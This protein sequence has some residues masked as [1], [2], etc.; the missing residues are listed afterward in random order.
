MPSAPSTSCWRSCGPTARDGRCSSGWAWT[1]PHVANGSRRRVGAAGRAAA[2][3]S[4]P[5]PRTPSASSTWPPR[6]RATPATPLSAEHLLLAALL[7][8][9]GTLGKML[10]E[11]GGS[12]PSACGLRSATRAAPPAR[13]DAATGRSR[14]QTRRRARATAWTARDPRRV[15]RSSAPPRVAHGASARRGIPW[16]LLLLL[17]VPISIV[18][19][20]V[21]HAPAV[22]VFFTAC[23][24]VLPLAGYMGEATEHLA[25]PHRPDHRRS[26]Q[27]DVRQ[28]GRAHH[29][30]RG[31]PRG[32]GRAGEGV[33]HRQHPRQPAAHPGSRPHRRRHH[34]RPSSS[35]IARTPG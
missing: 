29:R 3:T 27:R 22:W 5:I 20:Y 9:R 32:A 18:L 23:L 35:S 19:G 1:W 2:P 11:A 33:D 6:R 16:R 21:L 12:R 7:E 31:A 17:A 14:E 8:P 34:Q 25:P 26:A 13:P 4:W 30:H 28:R 10:A 24:G 15:R